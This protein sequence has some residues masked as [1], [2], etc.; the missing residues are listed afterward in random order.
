M[1]AQDA[2]ATASPARAPLIAALREILSDALRFVRAE[3]GV[4]RAEGT[5]A[6]KRAALAAGLLASAAITVLLV[7]IFLLGA[8]AEGI[9]GLLHHRWLG[10]LIMA[11]LLLAVA[12]ILGGLG[13]LT[14]RRTI[15]EGRRVTATMKEDLEWAKELL[16]QNAS[17]S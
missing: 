7:V 5:R 12:A 8:A 4:A 14:V 2:P 10:W 9:G 3:V 16:R 1:A 13:Y 11:G 15:A 6:A 17:G